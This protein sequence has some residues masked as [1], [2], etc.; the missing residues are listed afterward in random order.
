MK[1]RDINFPAFLTEKS[2][3]QQHET[4]RFELRLLEFQDLFAHRFDIGMNQECTVRVTPK[5]TSTSYNQTFPTPV[6]LKQDICVELELL[7]KNGLITT[8]P[9]SKNANPLFAQEKFY[10]KALG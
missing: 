3:F 8:L 1:N 10:E 9:F 6:N 2:L 4:S 7:H 5:D